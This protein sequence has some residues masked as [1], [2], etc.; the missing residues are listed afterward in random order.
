MNNNGFPSKIGLE[1]RK[2]KYTPGCRVE[3]IAMD[4]P[5]SSLIPGEQGTVQFVDSTGTVFVKWDSGSTLGAVYG[6][7]Q[8][9]KL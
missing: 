1:A 4:D 6:V 9:K 3:L 2:A 7:D 5:Y 8:I